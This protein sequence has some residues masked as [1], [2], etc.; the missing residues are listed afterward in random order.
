MNEDTVTTENKKFVCVECQNE[1]EVESGLEVGDVVE[2]DYCGLEY[3]V[4][5]VLD[6][7]EYKLVVVEEEK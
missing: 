3:E 1:V 5:E 2:C 4:L 7:G 6:N